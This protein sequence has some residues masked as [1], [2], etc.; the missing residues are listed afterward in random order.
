MKVSM[1]EYIEESI[2]EFPKELGEPCTSPATDHL[3]K[4]DKHGIK[5][6]EKKAQ[7]FHTTVARTLFVCKRARPGIQSAIVFSNNLSKRTR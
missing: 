2:E 3:F 1:K 6:V 7:H 5:P 4:A